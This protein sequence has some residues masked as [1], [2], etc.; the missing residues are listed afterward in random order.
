MD[1]A[2][3]QWTINSRRAEERS[4]ASD[5]SRNMIIRKTVEFSSEAEDR[6][7]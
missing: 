6:V 7:H 1:A 4:I 2:N 5:D 3:Y